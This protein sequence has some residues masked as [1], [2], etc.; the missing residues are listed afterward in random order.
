MSVF[1][2]AAMLVLQD[3]GAQPP[4]EDATPTSDPGV[5]AEAQPALPTDA[6]TLIAEFDSAY[7]QWGDL[8]AEMAARKARDRYIRQLLLSRISRT[9]LDAGARPEIIAE[10]S[11]TFAAVD[12]DNT[13]W[14]IGLLDAYDFAALNAAMP[15]LASDIAALVQHGDLAAQ[16]RLLTLV[17]PLAL[18]GEFNGQRYALLYDRVAVAEGRPQRYGSQFRCEDGEQVYPPLEDPETVDAMRAELGMEPLATYRETST[19]FYGSSCSN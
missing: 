16:Q 18:A 11:D 12:G 9:D 6:P 19:A 5:I 15:S 2:L 17:E 3:A 14:A 1:I 7:E 13:E 8:V 10:T 4:V